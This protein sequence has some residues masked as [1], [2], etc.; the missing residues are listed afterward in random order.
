M[1]LYSQ[2]RCFLWNVVQLFIG[3]PDFK[4]NVYTSVLGPPGKLLDFGCATGHI[5]T[6]FVGFEYY[7]LDVDVGAIEFA[8]ARFRH[9]PS[10]HFTAANILDHPFP[11]DYFDQ[12]LFAGTL[13]HLSDALAKQILEELHFCVKPGGCVHLF[14]PVRQ[15]K[16]RWPQR[17]MRCI[18][19]GKHSRTAIQIQR[20]VEAVGL[21]E[22]GTP[23]YY[24]TPGVIIRDCDMLYLQLRKV[25]NPG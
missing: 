13:H 12:V 22:L 2:I 25:G 15:D 19:R 8:K 6:A 5:S 4:R 18:D 3:V 11:E 16:D 23:Q 9:Q 7:G 20:L 10:L 24:P 1:F 14:D 21:Y 17:L